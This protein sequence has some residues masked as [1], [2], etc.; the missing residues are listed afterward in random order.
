MNDIIEINK[1]SF[2]CSKEFLIK[3][4][5]FF[6]VLY[7]TCIDDNI[8]KFK[9]GSLNPSVVIVSYILAIIHH[10][11]D[12]AISY[13]NQNSIYCIMKEY[14]CF[15]DLLKY[16]RFT[17]EQ[18]KKFHVD[19]SETF[20]TYKCNT[21]EWS[22][23]DI[24]LFTDPMYGDTLVKWLS[25]QYAKDVE[26]YVWNLV[27]STLYDYDKRRR[28][29]DQLIDNNINPFINMGS[30]TKQF[31][32]NLKSYSFWLFD[33]EFLSQINWKV[34]M[35]GGGTVINC[36][37]NNLNK[38][39]N[40]NLWVTVDDDYTNL[41]TLLSQLQKK[42]T[43]KF[44]NK[45]CYSVH[46]NVITMY[47][48]GFERNIQIIYEPKSHKEIVE[49]FDADYVKVFY[50][51][52]TLMGTLE[53]ARSL[54]SKS[55]IKVN[56]KKISKE[57]LVKVGLKDY[58]F[59]TSDN[60]NA[61]DKATIDDIM[62][63]ITNKYLY[64]TI[65][66]YD[67][68]VRMTFLIKQIMGHSV[69][70]Y[71]F[72][73][74][75]ENIVFYNNDIKVAIHGSNDYKIPQVIPM[76]D[77]I[78][79]IKVGPTI[80]NKDKWI[81]TNSI[82]LNDNNS[83]IALIG[84]TGPI[85]TSFKLLC[86]E[87]DSDDNMGIS[88][89][90]IKIRIAEDRIHSDSIDNLA[91]HRFYKDMKVLNNYFDEKSSSFLK[92]PAIYQSLIESHVFDG[93]LI[94]SI[95]LSL[96]CDRDSS[97]KITKI[98]TKLIVYGKS[99][100][101]STENLKKY[102][103]E[104]SICSYTYQVSNLSSTPL[105]Y[106]SSID[107]VPCYLE[108]VCHEINVIS[109]KNKNGED[110]KTQ[111]FINAHD[112]IKSIKLGPIIKIN[113]YDSVNSITFNDDAALIGITDPLTTSL[114]LL[115]FETDD[116]SQMGI[117]YNAIKIQ[118]PKYDII[119]EN[120]TDPVHAFYKNMEILDNYFKEITSNFIK[121]PVVYEPLI[122]SSVSNGKETKSI[123]LSFLCD[124]DASNKIIK[125]D[126]KLIVDGESIETSNEN[127]KKYVRKD[128]VCTYTYEVSHLI[129]SSINCKTSLGP[130]PCLVRLVC[131]K[132]E[133][134]THKIKVHTYKKSENGCF[135]YF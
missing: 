99:I 125:R 94:K 48:V 120:S 96:L 65:K 129:T 9:T 49:D 56:A 135:I 128:S 106:D 44:S 1:L 110:H 22:F 26:R 7:D 79:L 70:F 102:M 71:D 83:E 132:I 123:V 52:N 27:H 90:A 122:R 16:F 86:H 46:K 82:S 12:E 14:E 97:N 57:R 54:M 4:S 112:A 81:N 109:Y 127:L 10:L 100:E 75:I 63:I 60:V 23:E 29:M 32:E 8:P 20:V 58:M 89:D 124:R 111:Q 73:K 34:V 93:K 72:N 39:S 6:G 55:V 105:D 31:K 108:L 13:V 101:A 33:D 50:D 126:T 43:E 107:F 62:N 40:I 78:E 114:D 24:Q 74:M 92:Q 88:Y 133:V 131:H 134:D 121:N 115:C 28:I 66:E 76:C 19:L 61:I 119:S 64:P 80:N 53:F 18:I 84:I 11:H 68:K 98:N 36:L 118:M 59:N 85:A 77:A 5:I 116:D 42:L 51:G 21:H 130:I 35:I 117:N 3:N 25:K 113:K 30:L 95:R 104:D 41:F 103:N 38:W 45:V 17:N 37:N 15:V 2:A 69:V 67:D 47:C 91:A 87:R